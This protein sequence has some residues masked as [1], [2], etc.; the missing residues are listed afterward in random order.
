MR[1]RFEVVAVATRSG[2]TAA[3]AAREAG[4]TLATADYAEVLTSPEVDAV[5]IATRHDQHA[6][7]AKEA[8]G[9]GKG[10]LL[11]K[12]LAL[13]EEEL[14]SLLSA[15]EASGLPFLV[16]YNRRFSDATRLLRERRGAH[17]APLVAAYRVN[18]S[19]IAPSDWSNGPEGG[20]R[21]VGEAC[22]MVDFLQ[23][24]IG[25]NVDQVESLSRLGEAPDANFSAQLRFSDGSLALLLYTTAGH[26]DLPKERVE[27]FL[28]GEAAVLDDFRTLQT[29]K[30]GWRKARKYRVDKG[31]RNEWIAFHKACSSGSPLPIPL[32]QLRSV[33]RATFRIRDLARA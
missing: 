22:H 5:L 14:E 33:T 20:G 26:A 28:G 4:A 23:A 13:N 6:R 16:G 32:D 17:A 1:E 25:A 12:P 3:V 18:A 7:L 29:H 24:V 31:Y 27:V 21:A 19:P 11:E 9:A 8:L 15:V 2:L 10:V 30:S